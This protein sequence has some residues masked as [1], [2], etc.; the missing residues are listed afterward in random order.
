MI[1]L[2]SESGAKRRIEMWRHYLGPRFILDRQLV[3]VNILQKDWTALRDN[4][5][6]L[7]LE[8]KRGNSS[9][10]NAFAKLK[11]PG[12]PMR[13]HKA[14]ALFRRFLAE[15]PD[16]KTALL[17][18]ESSVSIEVET[19]RT[20][21][22][23]LGRAF[24]YDQV[25]QAMMRRQASQI[26]EKRN[27]ANNHID[28]N[29]T[30]LMYAFENNF[31]AAIV[32]LSMCLT[33][34]DKR[35]SDDVPVP[36]IPESIDEKWFAENLPPVENAFEKKTVPGWDSPG[37]ICFDYVYYNLGQIYMKLGRHIEAG[38]CFFG[39]MEST[40]EKRDHMIRGWA[41]ALAAEAKAKVA[42]AETKG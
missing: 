38:M 6:Y 13:E 2:F 27:I 24:Q 26:Q 9:L 34:L 10:D 36:G 33:P 16:L 21:A 7:P 22:E 31:E 28:Q 8:L 20:Q 5:K 39:F 40:D 14:V 3:A 12:D 11:D 29:L 25:S 32:S 41:E 30:G 35:A 4:L 23:S 37:T 42:P 17:T 19:L 18:V 1:G 15:D